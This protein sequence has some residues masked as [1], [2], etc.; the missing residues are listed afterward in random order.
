[1]LPSFSFIMPTFNRKN[2]I[3][4]AIDSVL[5]QD[6]KNYELIIIDDKSTDGTFE[7]IKKSYSKE[8]TSGIIKYYY[9]DEKKALQ[10]VE[11]SVLRKH[12]M[13]GYVT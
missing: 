11:M 6:Y 4:N 5:T 12:L 7:D 8:L 3:K 1:M 13:N 10:V 9:Q 2:L